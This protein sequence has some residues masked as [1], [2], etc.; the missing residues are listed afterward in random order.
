MSFALRLTAFLASRFEMRQAVYN[1][2]GRWIA[3]F[4]IL[5]AFAAVL[6]FPPWAYTFARQGAAVVYNPAPRSFVFI[7]PK[8]L[9]DGFAWGLILD[10]KRLSTELLAIGCIGGLIYCAVHLWETRANDA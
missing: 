1:T 6:L 3:V 2:R 4:C 7:P 5:A 10:W 9:N 8:P